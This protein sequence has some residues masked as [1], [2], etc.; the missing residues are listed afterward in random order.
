M[1]CPENWNE[2]SAPPEASVLFHEE[3]VKES[4]YRVFNGDGQETRFIANYPPNG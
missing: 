2:N 1:A 4:I 3:G